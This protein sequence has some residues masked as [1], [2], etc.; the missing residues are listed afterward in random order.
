MVLVVNGQRRRVEAD[1][2]RSLL[3]VLRNELDLT[4]AKYGCGEGQCG[5]CT[6]LLNGTAARS[7]QIECGAVGEREIVTIEGLCKGDR[8]HPLQQSFIDCDAM[9]CGYCTSG[10]ILSGVA[11]LHK[12]PDPSDAEIK[13][14]LNGNVCRCGA[15][16]RIVAAVRRAAKHVSS[17]SVPKQQARS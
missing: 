3:S 11:L 14:A 1:P 7:C 4:G 10:M 12:S 5:A 2:K 16:N 6:I 9:Q 17:A 8:L 15:Y 13:E